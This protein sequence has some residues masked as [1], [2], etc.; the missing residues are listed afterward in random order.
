MRMQQ[1]NRFARLKRARHPMPD[2]VRHALEHNHV[3]AQ[4]HARPPYQQN[5]YIGWILR[6][7][8]PETKQRRLAQMLRE[9][10]EGNVYMKMRYTPPKK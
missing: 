5:D 1:N 8:R 2:V 9:L 7:K 6:A 3:V 10:K 4:Y